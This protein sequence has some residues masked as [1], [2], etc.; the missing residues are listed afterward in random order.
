MPSIGAAK[1][2]VGYKN[3]S[4]YGAWEITRGSADIKVAVLDDGF[5]WHEDF[6]TSLWVSRYDALTN[7]SNP[8]PHPSIGMNTNHHGMA[9]LGLIA[10]K[11]NN[12][13]TDPIGN[14]RYAST[15]GLS[16]NV[17][18]IPVK[19]GA[20]WNIGNAYQ[21]A[22]AIDH[23]NSK[24]AHVINGSWGS[25]FVPIPDALRNAVDSAAIYGR[26]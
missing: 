12:L 23:A 8:E 22:N 14:S 25:P 26:S 17:R 20:N 19:M 7:D 3:A 5:E 10:S 13:V 16:P 6:D 11:H 21:I 9:V 1:T 15:A 24:G 18:I 4:N 2:T